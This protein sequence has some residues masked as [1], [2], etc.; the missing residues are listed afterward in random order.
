[1]QDATLRTS[2]HQERRWS[3]RVDTVYLNDVPCNPERRETK[4]YDPG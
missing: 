3:N 2:L 4:S 1:M